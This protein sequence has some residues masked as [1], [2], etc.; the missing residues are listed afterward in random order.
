MRRN[1]LAIG[2]TIILFGIIARAADNAP[3]VEGNVELLVHGPDSL[4]VKNADVHVVALDTMTRRPT[5]SAWNARTDASGVAQLSLPGG[6]TQLDV[7]VAGTGYGRTGLVEVIPGQTAKPLLPPLAPYAHVAG[8]V[9]AALRGDSLKVR[10]GYDPAA[11]EV[12]PDSAG[13]FEFEG[14]GGYWYLTLV[15]GTDFVAW[16]KQPLYVAP[17]ESTK[18]VEFSTPEKPVSISQGETAAPLPGTG[19]TVTWVHGT[20]RDAAGKPVQGAKVCAMATFYGGRRQGEMASTAASDAGG[21]Y[22]IKGPGGLSGFSAA[23]LATVPNHPPAW[24]WVQP[25]QPPEVFIP[26]GTTTKPGKIPDPPVV[27]LVLPDKGG[28]MTVTVLQDG[29]P[30]DKI[31]VGLWLQGVDVSDKPL[32]LDDPDDAEIQRAA[33]PFA[34]TAA[35]GTA[36]FENLS[37][38]IYEI[39]AQPGDEKSLREA[40]FERN[41][42][43]REDAPTAAASGIAVRAGEQKSIRIGMSQPFRTAHVK[44]VRADGKPMSA[45][46]FSMIYGHFDDLGTLTGGRQ[47]D[48]LGN[49]D[50]ELPDA[51]LWAVAFRYQDSPVRSYP[52]R[53]PYYSIG[54]ILAVS[55]SIPVDYRPTFTARRIEPGS[56]IVT[57]LDADGKPKH[58]VVEIGAS[59]SD[60]ISWGSTDDNGE[61]LFDKVPVW[62]D[63]K[64]T[65]DISGAGIHPALDFSDP[66]SPLPSND[67]LPMVAWLAQTVDV[68]PNRLA[69]VELKAQAVGWVRGHLTPR[70]GQDPAQIEIYPDAESDC[71]YAGA[72]YVPKDGEF[73]A[74]P[75]PAGKISLDMAYRFGGGG[76]KTTPEITII[77]GR[78]V[79]VDLTPPEPSALSAA[80]NQL[81]MGLSGVSSQTL[82][83]D[84]LTGHVY[85][86][87]GKTPALGAEVLYYEPAAPNPPYAAMTDALGTILPRGLWRPMSDV[88]P[89]SA[90]SPTEPVVVAFLPGASGAVVSPPPKPGEALRLKLPPAIRVEGS[91]TVGGKSPTALQGNLRVLAVYQG[92]GTLNGAMSLQTSPDAD[93]KFE[94]A[95]L[96]PGTYK[97]QAALDD[98]WLSNTVTL[99]VGAAPL[100]PLTLAI[101]APGCPVLIKVTGPDGKPAIGRELT[102]D[103]A[104]PLADEL[105]PPTW[106]TDGAGIINVPTLETGKHVI[107]VK[108]TDITREIDVPPLPGDI[109]NVAI[110]V[111]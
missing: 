76:A 102:I 54:G 109:A 93:G 83:A 82:G 70:A 79:Q 67:K 47:P 96:T 75:F 84:L 92:K 73:L 25:P 40:H 99:D 32:D 43:V 39:M 97:I 72:R 89:D 9:P 23:L 60:R 105:W 19:Q 64:L 18:E 71:V 46:G 77:P 11:P 52:L 28:S 58:C 1:I 31:A 16:T 21:N 3:P 24:A 78:V 94:L 61:V 65:V 62:R 41:S 86:A 33:C 34:V 6:V 49:Y 95:G 66:P 107:R 14:P 106:T 5:P 103:R 88:P 57:V 59:I 2:L 7:T 69:R 8:T 53:E 22:A 81:L 20:V 98:I 38:G 51:G 10:A 4:P 56:V 85:L 55:P 27:D 12:A 30:A 48:A 26:V 101:A 63:A 36:R 68:P 74:G 80:S 100:Q 50:A 111:P 44:G 91:V 87:D 15:R 42:I 17:G 35:D 90:D 104:G 13:H 29:K 37:P 110:T 108:G 45:D